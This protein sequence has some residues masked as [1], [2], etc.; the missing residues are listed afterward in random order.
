MLVEKCGQLKLRKVSSTL[1]TNY[2]GDLLITQEGLEGPDPNGRLFKK[3]K[4]VKSGSNHNM[5]R[6]G[7]CPSGMGPSHPV[8][9]NWL[10]RLA[11]NCGPIDLLAKP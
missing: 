2:W 11:I 4:G 9:E 5:V 10:L 7:D 8:S 6:C 3:E 1:L